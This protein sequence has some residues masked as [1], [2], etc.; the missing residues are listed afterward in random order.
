MMLCKIAS[1]TKGAASSDILALQSSGIQHDNSG[2][3]AISDE[4]SPIV[5]N[6][7]ILS[8]DV[9]IDDK[10]SLIF[11]WKDLLWIKNLEIFTFDLVDP[12]S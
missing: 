7:T 10:N 1:A 9:G 4:K 11:G 6:N 12:S 3:W 8:I 5:A 2:N